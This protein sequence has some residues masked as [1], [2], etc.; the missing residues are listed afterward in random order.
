MSKR[1]AAG[2]ETVRETTSQ[3]EDTNIT[4]RERGGHETVRETSQR[5]GERQGD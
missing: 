3:R 2:N 4:E 1:E 5:E